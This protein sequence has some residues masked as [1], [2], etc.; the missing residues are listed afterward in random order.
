MTV[1]DPNWERMFDLQYALCEQV[2]ALVTEA[3]KGYPPLW[4]AAT[5]AYIIEQ[6]GE[7]I[8]GDIELPDVTLEAVPSHGDA[9]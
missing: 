7:R 2:E 1:V 9:T 5:R 4:K 3:T 6:F 8:R